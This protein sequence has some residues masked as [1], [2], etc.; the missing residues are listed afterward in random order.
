M[1]DEWIIV[2]HWWNDTDGKN[3]SSQ[4]KL[5]AIGI[6]SIAWTDLKLNQS[7]CSKRPASNH[8]NHDM[9]LLCQLKWKFCCLATGSHCLKLC[10]LMAWVTWAHFNPSDSLKQSLSWEADSVSP[11]K[12]PIYILWNAEVHC[13]VHNSPPFVP[14]WGHSTSVHALLF[15]FF[16][17][18]LCLFS[19]EPFHSG[20]PT[21]A[22][23]EFL[24]TSVHATCPTHLISLILITLIIFEE[25]ESWSSILSI[26]SPVSCYCLVSHLSHLIF[27]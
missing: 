4:G 11:S 20:F 25:Y 1:I 15:C 2:E 17:I 16:K 12:E 7:L 8:L 19:T 27:K 10:K 14:V 3:W 13:H 21:K 22:M 9:P 26:F 24:F 5:C 6:L 23:H 18:P